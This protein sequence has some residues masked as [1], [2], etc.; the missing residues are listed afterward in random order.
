MLD[1]VE[2]NLLSYGAGRLETKRWVGQGEAETEFSSDQEDLDG[3]M[4]GSITEGIIDNIIETDN[5]IET[6]N[7]TMFEEKTKPTTKKLEISEEIHI[8]ERDDRYQPKKANN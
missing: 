1:W 7:R 2:P 6:E 3:W 8:Q 5:W 4:I